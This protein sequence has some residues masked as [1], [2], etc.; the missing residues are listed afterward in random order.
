VIAS[1]PRE[2]VRRATVEKGKIAG[3]LEVSFEDGSSWAFD[4]PKVHLKGAQQ[5]A[6][7]L[8]RPAVPTD[9]V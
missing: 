2:A 9:R 7:E 5:I 1:A 3:V 6:A 8:S 4:I